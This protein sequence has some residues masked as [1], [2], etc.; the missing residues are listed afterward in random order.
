M[1]HKSIILYSLLERENQIDMFKST[2]LFGKSTMC[3]LVLSKE[4]TRLEPLGFGALFSGVWLFLFLFS[5][6]LY[7][8]MYFSWYFLVIMLKSTNIKMYNL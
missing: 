5:L 3:N 7:F 1:A 4:F 2:L 6:I 8:S